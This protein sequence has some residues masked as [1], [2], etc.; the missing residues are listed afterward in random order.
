MYQGN[1]T[2]N[3]IGTPQGSIISPI[4]CNILMNEF[5]LYMDKLVS[6]FTKG[7]RPRRNP[8][9]K[10]LHRLGKLTEIHARN[11]PSRMPFDTTYK[12]LRW[13][14]YADD[15]LIGVIGSKE[16]CEDLRNKIAEFLKTEV[17]LTLHLG[18]TVITHARD[19][20]AH[21]LGCDI[22]ITP[23][24][25]RR[26]HPVTR[27]EETFLQKS[28]GR[29]QILAPITKLIA[30]LES[31]GIGRQGGKPTRWT[32]MIPFEVGQTVYTVLAIWRG[33]TNYYHMRDNYSSLSRLWYILKYSA[34]L[35]IASKEKGH[36]SKQPQEQCDRYS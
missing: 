36:K 9:Y 20:S 31:K 16:D 7:V 13:V 8:E 32:K 29:P 18:K 10:R 35:T 25:A 23:L 15:F 1:L 24:A 26:L 6:E 2:P 21:F 14:R 28:A 5:D 34:V 3:E 19:N 27:G 30:R 22:K 4:L 33:I 17:K 11:I 12:R